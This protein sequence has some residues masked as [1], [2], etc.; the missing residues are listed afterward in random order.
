MWVY[1]IHF[2]NALAHAQHY[3]GST[4]RLRGRLTD[5]AH[6]R[7]ARLTAHLFRT[8]RDWRVSQLWQCQ[9]TATARQIEQTLKRRHNGRH[10][11]PL[12]RP[13]P[14][15]LDATPIDLQNV[16]FGLDSISLRKGL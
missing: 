7:G 3:T 8:N 13:R 15:R 10:H 2:D 16:P 5:H 1:L 9:N 11:C 14:R 6:G 12:C 4:P